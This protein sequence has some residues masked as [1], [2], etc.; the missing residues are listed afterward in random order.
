M[1]TPNAQR[2]KERER[3]HHEETEVYRSRAL[4]LCMLAYSH[5][6]LAHFSGTEPS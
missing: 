2:K 3:D 4:E 6:L 5:A 1:T